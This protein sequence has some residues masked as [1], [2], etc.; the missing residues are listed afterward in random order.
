MIRGARGFQ[1]EAKEAQG[2]HVPWDRWRPEEAE[3]E[4]DL[5]LGL[6]WR[7]ASGVGV[8][9]GVR[10]RVVRRKGLGEAFKKANGEVPW[11]RAPESSCTSP[12]G[13]GGAGAVSWV[14]LGVDYAEG[15]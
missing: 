3:L 8:I 6:V 2:R 15:S 9:R 10:E 11:T 12:Q 5:E 1:I 7:G 14:L 13:S 4:L